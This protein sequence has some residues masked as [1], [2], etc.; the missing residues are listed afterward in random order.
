MLKLEEKAG[1][2][3]N[4]ERQVV[5]PIHIDGELIC[6]YVADFV[7]FRDD[8]RL[9]EDVKG[10]RTREYAMKRKMVRALYKVDILET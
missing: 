6:K 2:I 3:R 9:F 7:Y 8:K 4:L 10:F 1:L 5:L